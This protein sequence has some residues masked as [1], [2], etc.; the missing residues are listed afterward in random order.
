MSAEMFDVIVVGS[1]AGGGV[2]AAEL[3][4]C[5]RR[6][7]LLEDVVTTGG[8]MVAALDQVAATGAEVVLAVTIVDRGEAAGAAFAERGVPYRSLLTYRDLGIV[9]VGGGSRTASR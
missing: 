7:L 8:S 4:D 1:G 3:A 2:I 9:A 5:D 6:V